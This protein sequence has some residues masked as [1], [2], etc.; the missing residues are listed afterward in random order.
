M[1]VPDRVIEKTVRGRKLFSELDTLK[2]TLSDRI[3]AK[4]AEIQK[5]GSQLQSPSISEAG[6]E[7]IQKQLRDLDFE[8]KK[9]QDDSQT[10]FQR[11]QQRIVTQFQQEITPLVDEVAKEQ[12]LQ[13]V[14]TFQP[15]LV[16]YADQT[17]IVAFSDEV[18]KRYDAK[19]AGAA[20]TAPAAK[21]AAAA[22]A[23]PATVK[24]ATKPVAPK[25]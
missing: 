23:K 22:P 18:A 11:T 14:L 15:G 6:K 9:L 4:R 2:K 20:G 8:D 24:P 12:K 25:P 1:L 17:W 3:Q 19:Y 7:T 16:A 21:P 13:L 5:L 10:E